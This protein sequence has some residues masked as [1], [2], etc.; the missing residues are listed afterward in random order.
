[1]EIED[2][3]KQYQPIIIVLK[4]FHIKFSGF[5]KIGFYYHL[6]NQVNL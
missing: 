2:F 1:V 5:D 3:G 6:K 4:P